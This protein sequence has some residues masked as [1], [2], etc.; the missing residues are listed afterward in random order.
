MN[1]LDPQSIAAR[2]YPGY[3]C[4]VREQENCKTPLSM[5]YSNE[6]IHIYCRSQSAFRRFAGKSPLG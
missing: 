6:Q 1:L 4:H 5:V 2:E 3:K